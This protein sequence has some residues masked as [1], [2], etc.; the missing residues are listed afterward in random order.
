MKFEKEIRIITDFWTNYI[1]FQYNSSGEFRFASTKELRGLSVGERHYFVSIAYHLK[2][3]FSIEVVINDVPVSTF[4]RMTVG[5]LLFG[6][7][8]AILAAV[9]GMTT[10]PKS[11]KSEVIYL[12]DADL[13]SMIIPC[14]DKNDSI[15]LISTIS[16]LERCIDNNPQNDSLAIKNKLIKESISE[17]KKSLISEE[18]I[19]V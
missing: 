10:R 11:K 15:R 12:D 13:A 6:A 14:R 7:T 16:T 4:K 1:S 9:N 2:N 19:R 17:L 8:E 18:I 5:S 3:I